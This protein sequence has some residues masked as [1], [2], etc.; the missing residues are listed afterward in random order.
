[1]SI[2]YKLVLIFILISIIPMLIIG[3]FGYINAK[4]ALTDSTLAG[5]RATSEFTGRERSFSSLT[6]L[7]SSHRTTLLMAISETSWKT[8]Y[9]ARAM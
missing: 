2:R 5:L 4:D 8:S 3:Q 9:K 6:G 7:K 1:M